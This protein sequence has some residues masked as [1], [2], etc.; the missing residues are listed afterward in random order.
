MSLSM[1][2]D[3]LKVNSLRII[4]PLLV[5]DDVGNHTFVLPLP[6]DISYLSAIFLV[7]AEQARV[8]KPR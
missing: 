6:A 1:P 3:R 4:H 2:G 7:N 5:D 8:G